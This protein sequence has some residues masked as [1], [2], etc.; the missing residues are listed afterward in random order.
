MNTKYKTIKNHK[1]QKFKGLK[2]IIICIIILFTIY[3]IADQYWIVTKDYTI[4]SE[5][6]DGSFT[7]AMISDLHNMNFGNNNDVVIDKIKERSPDIIAVIGDIVDEDT[8]NMT[9]ALNVM[10]R[11]PNIATTYYISGNH[12]KYCP[13]YDEFK[14]ELKNNGVCNIL[15]SVKDLNVNGNKIYLLGINSYSLGDVEIPQYT[16]LMNRFCAKDGYKILLCHYPEYVP[17][18]FEQDK[19]CTTDFDLMLSGHTHGGVIDIPFIGG[20][21]APNQGIFPEYVKGLY[22]IDKENENPFYMCI[23]GGLG[24]TEKCIRVN[25]FPEITFITVTNSSAN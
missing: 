22:Y 3:I 7:I 18:F 19:Y 14:Q 13:T 23:T 5:K 11:L 16:N 9:P 20:M 8:Y 15:G 24:Q 25:N 12:D 17:Y 2:L 1:K 6:I 10:K 21:F 4:K